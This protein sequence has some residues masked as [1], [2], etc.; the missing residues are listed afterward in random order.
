VGASGPRDTAR[1]KPF[2]IHTILRT[3]HGNDYG[4]SWVRQWQQ[5]ERTA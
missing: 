4:S 1:A 5:R 2:H 3:P